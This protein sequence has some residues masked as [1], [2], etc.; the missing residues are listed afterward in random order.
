[1]NDELASLADDAYEAIRED[2]LRGRLGPGTPLSR[3]R[4]AED[5]KM[6]IVP[7]AEAL[8]RAGGEPPVRGPAP[9]RAPGRDARL[10]EA[11]AGRDVGGADAAM[12]GHVGYGLTEVSGQIRTMAASEW[13]EPRKAGRG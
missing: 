13:R 6:S 2:I 7:I 3:R 10:A 8:R 9:P 5:L 1:M 12:R 4:L 11:P